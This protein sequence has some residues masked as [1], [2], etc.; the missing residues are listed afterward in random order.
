MKIFLFIC[1]FIFSINNVFSQNLVLNPSF[2]N[3]SSCPTSLDQIEKAIHWTS[4]IDLSSSNPDLHHVCVDGSGLSWRVQIPIGLTGN[5]YP[6]T[7][8]AFAAIM[9]YSSLHVD[10]REYLQGELS[11]PLVAGN[12]YSVSFYATLA[13]YSKTGIS[14]LGVYFADTKF[15]HLNTPPPNVLPVTPQLDTV[16]H[17][18]DTVNWVKIE[19]EYIATGGERYLVIGNF[20]DDNNTIIF[21]NAQLNN[22]IDGHYYID[23]VSVIQTITKIRNIKQLKEFNLFPNPANQQ[24]TVE[25]ELSKNELA[26]IEVYNNLGQKLIHKELGII[27][28]KSFKLPTNDL[29]QG[30]Y[31]VKLVIGNQITQKELVILR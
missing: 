2:E 16:L 28:E 5:Q 9:G 27:Q 30:V 13:D 10:Y 29:P 23:D 1:C 14:N 6:R 24:V 22:Y 11:T 12:T 20:E 8:D 17:L 15:N 18:N 3:Y 4:P 21:P 26:F 25:L 19:W 7:G 31:F